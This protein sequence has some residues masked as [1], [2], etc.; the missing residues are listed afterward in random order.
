MTIHQVIHKLPT[1]EASLRR[2][3][4]GTS[5]TRNSVHRRTEASYRSLRP[6][7]FN[8]GRP[9]GHKPGRG[10]AHGGPVYVILMLPAY[11]NYS[12]GERQ[13]RHPGFHNNEE[14][15]N[16]CS[17][18]SSRGGSFTVSFRT[19]RGVPAIAEELLTAYIRWLGSV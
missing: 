9:V 7:R 18:A 1:I 15:A 3:A 11:G 16:F 10:I 8:R 17:G 12:G 13:A 14:V 5:V 19:A 6:T 4:V 2:R